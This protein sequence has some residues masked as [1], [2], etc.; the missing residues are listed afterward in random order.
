MFAA[1]F[2]TSSRRLRPSKVTPK[3]T[4]A[5]T[6]VRWSLIVFQVVSG[7]LSAMRLTSQSIWSLVAASSY[8]GAY[9]LHGQWDA[10]NEYSQEYC[11]SG[12]CLPMVRSQVNLTET[13]KSLAMITKVGVPGN[14]IIVGV[15]SYGRSFQMA[16]AGLIFS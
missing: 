4:V 9:G 2:Y 10:R 5:A 12:N 11:E 14:K 3:R 8:L 1:R 16:E 6:A 7:Q 15:T 13:R